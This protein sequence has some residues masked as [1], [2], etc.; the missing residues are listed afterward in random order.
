MPV[1]L[2]H[3]LTSPKMLEFLV[4]YPNVI[5]VI[6]DA[7]NI[8]QD[9]NRT[10]SSPVSTLLNIS[11]GLLS[12]CLNIQLICTFNAPVSTL[13][14]AL[15][16]KGRLIAR[17][18]FQELEIAKAQS[19]SDKLGFKNSINTLMT[20]GDIYNQDQNSFE[21]VKGNKIGF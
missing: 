9:R 1:N 21:E 8:M 2:I 4:D 5:F 16:R 17:Y 20:I 3:E 14:K 15:L 10:M 18:E 6:E 12:D 11:D 13:D 19:L 7:E